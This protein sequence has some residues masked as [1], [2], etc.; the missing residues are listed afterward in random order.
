[1][2]RRDRTCLSLWCLTP[3]PHATTVVVC[4]LIHVAQSGSS[5]SRVGRS[6]LSSSLGLV[7]LKANRLVTR[8]PP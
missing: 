1:M 4:P 6:W 2:L 7:A 5:P 8:K 3:F